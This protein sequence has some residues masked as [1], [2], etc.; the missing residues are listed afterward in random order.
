MYV[1]RM[2]SG[3]LHSRKGP[4]VHDAALDLRPAELAILVPLVG[5]LLFLS[6]WPAAITERVVAGTPASSS[7][8]SSGWTPYAPLTARKSEQR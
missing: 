8:A 1:L 2:I 5:I 3:V 7:S 4:A 6:A